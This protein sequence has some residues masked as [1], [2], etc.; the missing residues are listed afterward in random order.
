[1]FLSKFSVFTLLSFAIGTHAACENDAAYSVTYVGKAYTCSKLRMPNNSGPR[2]NLCQQPATLAACPHTCGTCCEDD[3]TYSYNLQNNPTKTQDCAFLTK[4]DKPAK[5]QFRFDTYCNGYTS[6]GV[7]VR[8][9]CQ[10]SCDF[11]F[12]TP[13]PTPAPSSAPTPAPT[14]APVA[15][16]GT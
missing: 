13:T 4:S 11:C 15:D 5:N 6:G 2:F 9:K 7:T 3:A 1:M 16:D 12:G 14:P 8:S 10:V